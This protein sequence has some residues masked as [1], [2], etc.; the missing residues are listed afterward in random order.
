MGKIM[1]QMKYCK[2]LRIA[3]L[4]GI[5]C[6]SAAPL[7]IAHADNSLL[8]IRAAGKDYDETSAALK[9]ELEEDITIAEFVI[10]ENTSKRD[11]IR[12]MKSVSPQIVVLMD[13]SAITLYKQ[14]QDELPA[15]LPVVPSVSLMASFTD[16]AI[17]GMR[18][19]SGIFYEVPVVSSIVNLRAILNKPVG[20]VGIVHREFLGGL[21]ARNTEFCANEK[22]RLL[23]YVIPDDGSIRSK[24]K[25]GLKFLKKKKADAIWVPNDS[26]MLT[27]KLL[28]SVWIPFVGKY[29]KPV[30]VGAEVLANPMFNFGTFAVIPDNTS[31]GIQ[32]A[33]MIL[34]AMDNDWKVEAGMVA[35][36]RSVYKII[37]FKQAKRL[38]NISE[39]NLQDVDKI[40]K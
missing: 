14:Y 11:I 18:N 38:F 30:I 7:F 19:A 2:Y 4:A 36:P 26:K 5:F 16:L 35:S 25:K 12:K 23:S 21:V 33:E 1:N 9:D 40:L 10:R 32:A 3:L 39:D 8:I 29:K 37:N 27:P 31:L 34:D 6:F 20:K 17:K 28:Q 22:I 15:S 13:N 24:L